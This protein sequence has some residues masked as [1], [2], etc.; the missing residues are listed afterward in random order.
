M[1]PSQSP[2]DDAQV[3]A[4]PGLSVSSLGFCLWKAPLSFAR[5][6]WGK[7]I[8]TAASI[9]G[10]ADPSFGLGNA[11]EVAGRLSLSRGGTGVGAD[12]GEAPLAL[13]LVVCWL[14]DG[15][16]PGT[17]IVL[18]WSIS[19]SLE[20]MLLECLVPYLVSPMIGCPTDAM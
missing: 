4:L 8:S 20:S 19:D 7:V 15:R 16:M 13:V 14:C 18:V 12:E 9:R 3:V 11:S 1:I 6:G 5:E 10:K 17:T 2:S